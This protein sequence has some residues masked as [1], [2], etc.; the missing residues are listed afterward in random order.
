MWV[1]SFVGM[2]LGSLPA[3]CHEP[4]R[5]ANAQCDCAHVRPS[6]AYWRVDQRLQYRLK[7]EGRPADCL[8]HIDGIK[9]RTIDPDAQRRAA[10][11]QIRLIGLVLKS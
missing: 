11:A 3:A 6:Q 9:A 2:Q 1:G 4:Q 8:E 5:I 7:I 10:A